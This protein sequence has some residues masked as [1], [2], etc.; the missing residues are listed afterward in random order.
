MKGKLLNM[1]RFVALPERQTPRHAF[2]KS[3]PRLS[4]ECQAQ[5]RGCE[6]QGTVRAG[7]GLPRTHD[8]NIARVRISSRSITQL[9]TAVAMAFTSARFIT[10]RYHRLG[11]Q[12]TRQAQQ[13]TETVAPAARSAPADLPAEQD[14]GA[15]IKSSSE[16]ACARFSSLMLPDG[17]SNAAE[18]LN[19]I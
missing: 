10:A 4:R 12:R 15:A 13:D 2:K 19:S 6:A 18:P 16:T 8:P 7:R 3:S 1:S 11:H 14:T 17:I 5:G 9:A